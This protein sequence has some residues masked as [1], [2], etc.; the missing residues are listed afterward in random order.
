[1]TF[2]HSPHTHATTTV[3]SFGSNAKGIALSNPGN[4]SGSGAKVSW[5][6]FWT[7]PGSTLNTARRAN[8]STQPTRRVAALC[9]AVCGIGHKCTLQ[10]TSRF[11]FTRHR[12]WAL[13][14]CVGAKLTGS[15]HSSR[16]R[17]DPKSRA[18]PSAQASPLPTPLPPTSSSLNSRQCQGFVGAGDV[19]R[20]CF[21]GFVCLPPP[22]PRLRGAG[23]CFVVVSLPKT[24]RKSGRRWGGGGGGK[25]GTPKC[26][27][28]K[29]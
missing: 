27:N 11:Q 18:P 1:M 5:G 13:T 20:D 16:D 7:Y 24:S 8:T 22:P 3:H 10:K 28:Q 25:G 26:V 12:S 4:A 9:L 14:F 21:V 17:T 23:L 6:Y 29:K 19:G 2:R 15:V